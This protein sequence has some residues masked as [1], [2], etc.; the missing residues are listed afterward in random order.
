MQN[1]TGEIA[2]SMGLRYVDDAMSEE[3]LAEVRKDPRFDAIFWSRDTSGLSRVQGWNRDIDVIASEVRRRGFHP[4]IERER[5]RIE[6][7]AQLR[8]AEF[9]AVVAQLRSKV[10]TLSDS[11]VVVEIMTWL[12]CRSAPATGCLSPQVGAAGGFSTSPVRIF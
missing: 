3:G 10:P 7:G 6:W 8:S 1:V 2:A 12:L 11:Q 4:F 9:D 5:D